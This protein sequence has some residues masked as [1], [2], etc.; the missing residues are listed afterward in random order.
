MYL[1]YLLISASDVYSFNLTDENPKWTKVPASGKIV[2]EKISTR[3]DTFLQ[4]I[5]HHQD[6]DMVNVQLVKAFMFL[7]VAWVQLSMRNF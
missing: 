2:K 1:M 4:V 7:E 3:D 6:L 5:L